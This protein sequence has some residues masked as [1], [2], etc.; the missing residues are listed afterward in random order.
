[1]GPNVFQSA[2]V[3]DINVLLLSAMPRLRVP[4]GESA[5][6]LKLKHI[7]YWHSGA[8]RVKVKLVKQDHWLLGDTRNRTSM[9][10]VAQLEVSIATAL[11]VK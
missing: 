1:M 10:A 5:G 11:R 6:R 7:Q 4:T 3:N 8:L 9:N 2:P